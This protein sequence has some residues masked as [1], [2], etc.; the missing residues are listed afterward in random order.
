[1][2]ELVDALVSK[3]N[4]VIPCRFDSGSGYIKPSGH[5]KLRGFFYACIFLVQSAFVDFTIIKFGL[6]LIR[7]L[8][9]RFFQAGHC[10]HF[11]TFDPTIVI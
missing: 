4:G 2:A 7:F 6:S 11:I 5:N 1:M 9:D 8:I 10:P 3:T